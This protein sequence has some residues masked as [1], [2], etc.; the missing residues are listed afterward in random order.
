VVRNIEIP[1]RTADGFVRSIMLCDL[2]HLN[3]WPF[4][5]LPAQE[6]LTKE[7]ARSRSD[8]TQIQDRAACVFPTQRSGPVTGIG[9]VP[10]HKAF[11]REGGW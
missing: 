8:R 4:L 3:S 10:D 7:G 2:L 6:L 5:R 1:P 9:T 11:A